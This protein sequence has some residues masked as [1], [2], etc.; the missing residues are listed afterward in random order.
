[1]Q[2]QTFYIYERVYSITKKVQPNPSLDGYKKVRCSA[3]W[4]HVWLP[5]D[6]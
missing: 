2:K 6:Q 1:M 3:A 4:S 5:D